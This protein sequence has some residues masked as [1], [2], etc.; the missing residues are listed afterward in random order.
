[1]VFFGRISNRRENYVLVSQITPRFA[2]H[3][4]ETGTYPLNKFSV[5][6]YRPTEGW[7]AGLAEWSR[8]ALLIQLFFTTYSNF[9]HRTDLPRVAFWL[10]SLNHC[11]TQPPVDHLSYYA[12]KIC[13][14]NLLI[15]G[16]TYPESQYSGIL[17]IWN[18]KNLSGIPYPEP[19]CYF[20]HSSAL[21]GIF[22]IAFTT[23]TTEFSYR[24]FHMH[25]ASCQKC[26]S[27]EN[28]ENL[29]TCTSCHANFHPNCTHP[30]HYLSGKK[31]MTF[32]CR[33]CKSCPTCW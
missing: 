33:A 5:L 11:A 22:K 26:E 17:F 4:A 12:Q 20:I 9:K 23:I 27:N 15:K 28:I 3:H 14:K 29:V 24:L 7:T 31:K 32:Q 1:L 16:R 2:Q 18:P 10:G 25:T 8:D 13:E 30:T 6:N 21:L 19:V